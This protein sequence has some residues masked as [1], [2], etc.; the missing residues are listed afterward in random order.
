MLV[1]IMPEILQKV[2]KA[3]LLV[4]GWGTEASAVIDMS[5][6]SITR[7]KVKIIGPVTENEK[8]NLLSKSWVF[9]NPSIGEGWGIS[10]IEANL[11]GTPV[12]AFDVAGLS[13]SVKHKE[14]GFL[15]KNEKDLI[16]KITLLLK[17][18]RLRTKYGKNAL[19]W[20][21]KFNWDDAAVQSS[22]LIEKVHEKRK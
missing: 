4:A 15:V 9:V 7:R 12:V 2:P 13:E 8:S 14:T 20:A 22:R 6:R 1:K 11:H 10:V 3:S 5:M 17:D 18:Q 21:K 19:V 16:D